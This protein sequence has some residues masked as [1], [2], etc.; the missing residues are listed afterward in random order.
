MATTAT[1]NNKNMALEAKLRASVPGPPELPVIQV[2]EEFVR[3]L[4]ANQAIIACSQTGSGKSTQIPRYVLNEQLGA[5]KMVACTQPR[6]YVT[7]TTAGFVAES[8]NVELGAEV[9][10][11]F[12]YLT[13]GKLLAYYANGDPQF[14]GYSCIIIDEALE[15]TLNTDILMA[16]LKV[17]MASRKNLKVIIMA[18]TLDANK[19]SSY[20]GGAPILT[21]THPFSRRCIFATVH[22]GGLRTLLARVQK[23][24][25]SD[26]ISGLIQP[27]GSPSE[28]GKRANNVPVSPIW[29]NCL[30]EAHRFGC[31]EDMLTIV[32][33]E[34]T[35][36]SIFCRPRAIQWVAD[37]VVHGFAYPQSD[38]ITN[39]NA[40]HAYLTVIGKPEA[41][42]WCSI[43][44][45]NKEKLDYVLRIRGQLRNKFKQV[46]GEFKTEGF[47][48]P[49]YFDR[50]RKALARGLFTQTAFWDRGHQY[51]TLHENAPMLLHPNSALRRQL[52]PG[53]S[54]WIVVYSELLRTSRAYGGATTAIEPEWIADLP[55]FQAGR[56]KV[57]FDGVTIFMDKAW[58]SL[59]GARYSADPSSS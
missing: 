55:H 48:T 39:L 9:N 16:K 1:N 52:D 47:D 4:K 2:Y 5:G 41:A 17:A 46:R 38:H 33:I 21:I 10:N 8:M 44:F 59:E 11:L 18:A 53:T 45:L 57:R 20:F 14:S 29:F 31:I 35:D 34:N 6:R 12:F 42:Q 3:M 32:A 15:R 25:Y 49:G 13:D 19:F 28:D 43:H 58:Q 54:G 36:G 30:R 22:Q 37:E 51:R 24:W 23:D 7:I 56:F 50:L 26:Q 27:D 40:V